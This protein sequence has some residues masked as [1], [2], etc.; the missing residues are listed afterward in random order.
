M[1]TLPLVKSGMNSQPTSSADLIFVF[2]VSFMDSLSFDEKTPGRE[3]WLTIP[4]PAPAKTAG[5]W[6]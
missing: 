4:R 5:R 6:R 2:N 3:S 1:A